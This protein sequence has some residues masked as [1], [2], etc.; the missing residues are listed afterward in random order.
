MLRAIV[1]VITV[2]FFKVIV[3]VI[4]FVAKA[5]GVIG[6]DILNI[7]F[8][9]KRKVEFQKT[10]PSGKDTGEG[11]ENNKDGHREWL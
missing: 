1:A 7:Y 11:S 6:K 10:A 5:L 8:D 2:I 3:A 4:L 9:P